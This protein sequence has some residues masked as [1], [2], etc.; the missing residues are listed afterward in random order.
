MFRRKKVL[1]GLGFLLLVT[2]AVSKSFGNW[3]WTPISQGTGI[4]QRKL[5]EARN[6][7]LA[8]SEELTRANEQVADLNRQLEEARRAQAETAQQLAQTHEKLSQM[9]NAPLRQDLKALEKDLK[10]KRKNQSE[11]L[12]QRLKEREGS[13]TRMKKNLAD[14]QGASREFEKR[15]I[16]AQLRHGKEIEELKKRM[17]DRQ[18]FDRLQKELQEAN[19]RI[20]DLVV[21]LDLQE[22]LTSQLTESRSR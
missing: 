21:S 11:E 1:W 20:A 9:M 7:K 5:L 22:Q 4:L 10:Q 16:Q 13:F 2:W 12:S 18:E 17:V 15:L 8:I 19:N 14:A 3:V 6:V